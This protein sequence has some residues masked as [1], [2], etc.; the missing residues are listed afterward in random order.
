MTLSPTG[1]PSY[2]PE[3][4]H[5]G[6]LASPRAGL[7][8]NHRLMWGWFKAIAAIWIAVMGKARQVPPVIRLAFVE[9]LLGVASCDY[10]VYYH[11]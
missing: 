1:K 8:A 3:P 11:L 10:V 2:S 7:V 5:F 4:R 6:L 9:M